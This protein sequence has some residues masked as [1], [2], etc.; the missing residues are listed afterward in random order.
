MCWSSVVG[1]VVAQVSAAV[2]ALA[3]TFTQPM[4]T[5]LPG[6]R[7]LRSALAALAASTQ[8]T[9]NSPVTTALQAA[10]AVSFTPPEAA[11]APHTFGSPAAQTIYQ[12]RGLMAA[13]VAAAAVLRP[14]PFVRVVLEYLV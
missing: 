11:A 10:S 7:L 13:Q 12:V 3:P 14:A 9:N 8:V 4:F 5:Y 1:A 2:V 6:L